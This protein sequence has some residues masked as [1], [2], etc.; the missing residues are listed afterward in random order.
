M[1]EARQIIAAH[2]SELPSL[3]RT[4]C[5]SNIAKG[6]FLKSAIKSWT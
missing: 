1:E 4:M 6:F 5:R 2:D 3:T